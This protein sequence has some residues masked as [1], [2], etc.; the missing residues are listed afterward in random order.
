MESNLEKN[1]DKWFFPPLGGGVVQGLSQGSIDLFKS[2]DNLG[3]ESAQNCR[4]AAIDD[5]K[6]VVQY[7]LTDIDS[8]FFP[9]RKDYL[10]RLESA[11]KFFEDVHGLT[12]DEV[13][14]IQDFIKVLNKKTI[15][16]LVIS[17]FNTSGLDG[18][19]DEQ[20]SRYYRFTKSDGISAEQ[21]TIPGTY[22]HGKYALMNFSH[23]RAITALSKFKSPTNDKTFDKLFIGMAKLCTHRDLETNEKT[24]SHGFYC[25][26]SGNSSEDWTAYR[27]DDVDKIKVPFQREENG[28]D[29]YVWGFDRD[30]W[31]I[32]LAMGLIY[33]FFQAILEDKIEFKIYKEDNLLYSITKDSISNVLKKLEADC[34]NKLSEA[35]WR[36]NMAKVEG[37]IKCSDFESKL[38]KKNTKFIAGL[39]RVQLSIY[40]NKDDQSLRN[41]YCLMRLPLM[42]IQ[43]FAYKTSGTPYAAVCKLLDKEGNKVIAD[44]EDPTHTKLSDDYVR[45]VGLKKHHSACLKKLR[46]WIR[47]QIDLL[48]PKIESFQDIPGLAEY[49]SG[50]PLQTSDESF[51]TGNQE[52]KD[53]EEETFGKRIKTGLYTAKPSSFYDKKKSLTLK[54]KPSSSGSKGGGRGTHGGKGKASGG[55]GYGA[56]AGKGGSELNEKGDKLSIISSEDVQIIRTR[57]END[58][59]ISKFRVKALTSINGD[60][61]LGYALSSEGGNFIPPNGAKLLSCSIENIKCE[62]LTFK[63]VNLK[64]GCYLDFELEFDSISNMAIG[65]Y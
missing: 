33:A 20:S 29:I 52:P 48:D 65:A 24:Q 46:Q 59:K 18:G 26:K 6:V 3:R 50:G 64:Q 34:K 63:D 55:G 7:K 9:A 35:E 27:N 49:L 5:S 23:F 8:S 25:I 36:K 54:K 22:G 12:G 32:K 61:R 41:R 2:T 56:G 37:Y 30:E 13:K 62:N 44:L 14:R 19:E 16:T 15:P 28:T 60:L 57:K 38:V 40:S 10:K 45:S 1:E 42:T 31:D 39:G 4:G 11:Q 43:D 51:L 47:Q 17:D 21:G 53:N 58:N